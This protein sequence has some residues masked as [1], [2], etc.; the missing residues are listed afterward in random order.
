VRIRISQDLVLLRQGF[1][2]QLT[3]D[4]D[5]DTSLTA[6]VVTI[7]IRT[8]DFDVAT[9]RFSIGSATLTN[10]PYVSGSS[11]PTSVTI[12]NLAAGT[13]YIKVVAFSALI[14]PGGSSGST[15]QASSEISITVP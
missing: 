14:P 1:E 7:V 10:V 4:N 3:I 8:V 11:A 9:D 2:A 6:I 13:Y 5:A 12:S 15:S